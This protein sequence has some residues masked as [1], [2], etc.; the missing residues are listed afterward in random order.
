VRC[1]FFAPLFFI[2]FIVPA[3]SQGWLPLTFW[4]LHA[5]GKYANYD[6]NF[7]TQQYYGD[8]LANLVLVSRAGNETVTD[9]NGNLSVVGPNVP[10]ISCAG[11]QVFEGRTNELNYTEGAFSTQWVTTNASAADATVIGPDGGLTGSTVTD[12]ATNS[13]HDISSPSNLSVVSG[14]TYIFSCY[15]HAG[16]NSLGFGQLNVSNTNFTGSGVLNINLSTG[17]VNFENTGVAFGNGMLPGVV[18]ANGWWRP[19][20]AETA[21]STG[22]S[23][24][25]IFIAFIHALSDLRAPTYVGVGNTIDVTKCNVEP[26][27]A[28]GGAFPTPYQPATNAVVSRPTDNITAIGGLATALANTTATVVANVAAVPNTT[29]SRRG[30]GWGGGFQFITEPSSNTTSELTDNTNTTVA[31]YGSGTATGGNVKSAFSWGSGGDLV[32]NNGSVATNGSISGGTATGTVN[33]GD[34]ASGLRTIDTNFLRLGV[35]SNTQV[36]GASLQKLT[37]Q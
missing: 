20:F 11:L 32:S 18:P 4:A 21:T 27:P 12:N 7:A 17:A 30:L 1:R 25:N 3:L 22:S 15:M 5:N 9:C 24:Q 16:V 19:W 13:F 8:S 26:M 6:L 36:T 35:F 29:I 34:I 23:N 10:A 2:C 31:T 37:T 33:I 28:T 14:T